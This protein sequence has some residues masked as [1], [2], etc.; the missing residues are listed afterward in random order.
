MNELKAIEEIDRRLDEL[1]ISLLLM[2]EKTSKRHLRRELIKFIDELDFSESGL[3]GRVARQRAITRFRT[4]LTRLI[5]ND[6]YLLGFDRFIAGYK[7]IVNLANGYFSMLSTAYDKNLYRELYK[8]SLT[9]LKEALASQGFAASVSN[10]VTN[11]MLQ[12]NMQGV[13]KSRLKEEVRKYFE[14]K[15]ESTRYVSQITNDT[16]YTMTRIYQNRIAEDLNIGYWL[17]AG[18]LI[19]TSRTFCKS[20]TGNVYTTAEVKGWASMDWNGKIGGTNSENIFERLGGYGCRHTLR[21]ISKTVY[22]TIKRNE[23]S[24]AA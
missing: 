3:K 11:R 4:T 15:N 8:D 20:R 7:E 22:E 18:T 9:I 23:N 24:K 19:A 13:T 12:W 2:F 17:Y 14:A 21:P 5:R 6:E 10:L 1:A 16:L